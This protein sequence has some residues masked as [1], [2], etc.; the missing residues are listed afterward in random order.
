MRSLV[1]ALSLVAATPA[2]AGDQD[3]LFLG[4]SYTN[5]NDLPAT[6]EGLLEEGIAVWADVVVEPHTRGGAKLVDHLA[7]AD[8]TNGD[9]PLKAALGPDR[10]GWHQRP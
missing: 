10:G 2:W 7:N 5:R 3:I 8:G 4:N 1:F 9:T 6:V